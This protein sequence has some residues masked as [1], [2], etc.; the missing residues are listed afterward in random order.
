MCH[1]L[2][3]TIISSG[4]M[5]LQNSIDNSFLKVECGVGHNMDTA[6]CSPSLCDNCIDTLAPNKDI[7]IH[8]IKHSKQISLLMQCL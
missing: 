3:T 8:K 7:L 6:I 4:K 2:A 1:C 5:C